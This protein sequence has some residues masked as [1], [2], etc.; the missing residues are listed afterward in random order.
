MAVEYQIAKVAIINI[1]VWFLAWTPYALICCIG[2]FGDRQLITP[3]VS[4][5]ASYFAKLASALNPIVLAY[6]HA[7]FR[8]VLAKKIPCLMIENQE[9]SEQE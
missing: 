9:I 4:Q 6:S 2:A 8:Y 5:L 7:K 1:L 3:V